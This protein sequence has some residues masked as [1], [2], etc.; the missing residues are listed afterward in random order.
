M[1][2]LQGLWNF[3]YNFSARVLVTYSKMKTHG[4]RIEAE[5]KNTYW[6]SYTLIFQHHNKCLTSEK[7][8][9][10]LFHFNEKKSENKT[11]LK[12]PS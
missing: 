11:G 9:P 10:M 3:N 12:Y 4:N 7:M 6:D 2:C 8:T 5:Y 1:E